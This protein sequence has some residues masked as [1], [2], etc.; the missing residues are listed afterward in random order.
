MIYLHKITKL[1]LLLNPKPVV[2]SYIVPHTQTNN[3]L[4]SSTNYTL[5][6]E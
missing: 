4:D 6:L 2:T 1:H 3:Y 5:L